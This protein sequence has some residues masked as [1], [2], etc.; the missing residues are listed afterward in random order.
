MYVL[1]FSYW[2]KKKI[3]GVIAIKRW[4]SDECDMYEHLVSVIEQWR[5]WKEMDKNNGIK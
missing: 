5:K 2:I 1:I 4:H 3:K